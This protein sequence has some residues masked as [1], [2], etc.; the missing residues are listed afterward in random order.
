MNWCMENSKFRANWLP[1]TIFAVV[2]FAAG[3]IFGFRRLRDVSVSNL[4]TLPHSSSGNAEHFADSS[5]CGECHIQEYESYLQSGHARTFWS[6]RNFP[7]RSRFDQLKFDD[8]ERNTTFHYH[9]TKS[10]IDVSVPGLFDG[11]QFPLQFAFGSGDHAITLVTLT[12]DGTGIPVGIEHRVSWFSNMDEAD[13]TPGQS[14]LTVQHDIEHFG[15]IIRGET[16]Q[17]CFECHT[18]SCSIRGDN[19]IDLIPNVG[20]ERC[21]SSSTLHAAAMDDT[22]ESTI[23]GFKERPWRTAEQIQICAECHRGVNNVKVSQIRRDNPKIVRY[24]PVG[25]VQSKCYIESQRL[26]CSTCH[27]PHE[28]AAKRTTRDYELACLA[29]HSSSPQ[30]TRCSVSPNTGCI[31]CHMPPVEL[32]PSVSF[33]DHWIRI[34]EKGDPPAV[35]D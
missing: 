10:G 7:F 28:H 13:L 35:E 1:L 34:R 20:C 26:L 15:R 21:H 18:T 16:L 4:P 14:G 22:P 29:C 12:P 3:V 2:V 27:D 17:Q 5:K 25:L 19:L 6:T 8:P 33:H 30:A 24:Q 31:A 9:A 32:H 23:T 11:D